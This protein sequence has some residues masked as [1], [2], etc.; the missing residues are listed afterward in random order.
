M[1]RLLLRRS[2][3]TRCLVM[4]KFEPMNRRGRPRESQI[5]SPRAAI[6]HNV[7]LPPGVF[8]DETVSNSAAQARHNLALAYGV[9]LFAVFAFLAVA[10]LTYLLLVEVVKRALFKRALA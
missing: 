8:L 4:S 1:E 5:T 9:G 6:Q 10:T 7:A 3:P 2:S